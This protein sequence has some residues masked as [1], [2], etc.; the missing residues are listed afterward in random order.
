MI[1]EKYCVFVYPNEHSHINMYGETFIGTYDTMEEAK[2]KA[3]YYVYKGNFVSIVK[4]VFC[5]FNNVELVM[6]NKY[7]EEV[8]EINV[9]KWCHFMKICGEMD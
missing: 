1:N 3:E 6:S 9:A 7:G 4:N 2:G 5:T 8:E